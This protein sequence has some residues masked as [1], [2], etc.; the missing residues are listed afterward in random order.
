MS[1]VRRRFVFCRKT[2]M[3]GNGSSSFFVD[4]MFNDFSSLFCHDDVEIIETRETQRKEK[5]RKE[6]NISR[7]SFHQRNHSDRK[8]Q[9]RTETSQ[10]I[11]DVLQRALPMFHFFSFSPSNQIK[12][13]LL[14]KNKTKTKRY[15]IDRA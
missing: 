2:K 9:E 8:R 4:L 5:K 13:T 11:T 6:E 15:R 1:Y 14:L 10:I 12:R 7:T 3:R